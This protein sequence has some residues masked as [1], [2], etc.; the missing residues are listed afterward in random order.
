[1]TSVRTES[2]T[3]RVVAEISLVTEMPA[4]LKNAIETTLPPI[5]AA[6]EKTMD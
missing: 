4:K 3:V 1:M 5:A 6:A 2:N